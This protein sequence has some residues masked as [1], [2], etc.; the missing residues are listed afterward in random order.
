MLSDGVQ[1]EIAM[2]V[3]IAHVPRTT[4]GHAQEAILHFLQGGSSPSVCDPGRGVV[5]GSGP[6]SGEAGLSSKTTFLIWDD[7]AVSFAKSWRMVGYLTCMNAI[8]ASKFI[9]DAITAP[10]LKKYSPPRQGDVYL[11]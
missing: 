8:N 6:W 9:T 2:E 3:D 10:L 7:W 1:L 4:R 5:I 11:S